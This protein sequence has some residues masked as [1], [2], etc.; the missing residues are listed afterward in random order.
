M[1]LPGCVQL[2][3]LNPTPCLYTVEPLPSED[4]GGPSRC[5]LEELFHILSAVE[6]HPVP[7]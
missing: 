7:Q 3:C 4:P 1:D 6:P 5:G 2:A